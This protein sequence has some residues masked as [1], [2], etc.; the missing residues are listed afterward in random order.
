[1]KIKL[2]KGTINWTTT[3]IVAS[4]AT[5]TVAT[6]AHAADEYNVVKGL[7]IAGKPLGM[8]GIDPV[9]MFTGQTPVIGDSTHSVVHDGVDYYFAD[10]ETKARFKAD[11]AAHLPQ[12]GGFCAYG[13]YAGAKLDGD[14]R[15]ADIV[16]GKLYLFVNAATLEKYLEDPEAVIAGTN[17]KW[18]G[19]VNTPVS[20]L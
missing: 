6:W 18:P 19:I 5:L 15:Y 4:V 7:T 16:D 2:I 12:F 20:D 17:A 13:V 3:L 10:A 8:H 11:P 14:V 1:M 9:S